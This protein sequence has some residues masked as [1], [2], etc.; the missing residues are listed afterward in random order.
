MLGGGALM[1]STGPIF[2]RHNG[3]GLGRAARYQLVMD[4]PASSDPSPHAKT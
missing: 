2:H 1:L 3:S 4:E